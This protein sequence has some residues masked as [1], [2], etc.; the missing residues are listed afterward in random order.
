MAALSL[1]SAIVVVELIFD[2]F[3]IDKKENINDIYFWETFDEINFVFCKLQLYNYEHFRLFQTF[4]IYIILILVKKYD[5]NYKI[6]CIYTNNI[7]FHTF[8]K[9][10]SRS[11]IIM[12][13]AHLSFRP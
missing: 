4:P 9:Y 3:V 11:L 2:Y 12:I 8:L 1:L 5:T 10:K 6:I 13:Q 7:L